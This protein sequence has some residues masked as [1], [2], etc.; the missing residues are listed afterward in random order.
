[1]SNRWVD[2][3]SKSMHGN[4]G[5]YTKTSIMGNIC[6]KVNVKE[7]GPEEVPDDSEATIW[8]QSKCPRSAAEWNLGCTP[9]ETLTSKWHCHDLKSKTPDGNTFH[10][11]LISCLD[12]SLQDI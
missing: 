3:M 4:K 1:M 11:N 7:L 5:K 8:L 10:I 9:Y 6:I 12:R 2:H